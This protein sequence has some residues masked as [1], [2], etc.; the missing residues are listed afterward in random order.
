MSFGPV[1]Y[2]QRLFRKIVC[3]SFFYLF[4]AKDTM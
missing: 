1:L 4:S 2:V 3:M